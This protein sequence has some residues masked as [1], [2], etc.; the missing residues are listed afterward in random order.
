MKEFLSK[1]A[2]RYVGPKDYRK[3]ALKYLKYAWRKSKKVYRSTK[4]F[5]IQDQSA[6]PSWVFSGKLLKFFRTNFL[7]HIS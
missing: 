4:Q 3:S 5:Y 2:E 7:W 1:S 6:S